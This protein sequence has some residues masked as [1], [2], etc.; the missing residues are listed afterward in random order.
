MKYADLLAL[1]RQNPDT[2]DFRALRLAYADSPEYNPYPAR[3]PAEAAITAT[4]REN[5]WMSALPAV[6]DFLEAHYLDIAAH[7]TAVRI[8]NQLNQPDQ[9]T[10][11]RTFARRLLNSIVASGDGRS[12][13]TAFVVISISEEY[14]LLRL[15]GAH[16]QMQSL[17]RH[18]GHSFDVLKA[19]VPQTSGGTA[20]V[21]LYFN[22]DIPTGWLSRRRA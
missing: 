3:H 16:L 12:P 4:L 13:E 9:E 17:V 10:Y 5:D 19:E 21:K 6:L 18:E 1:A 2:A 14:A 22:V 7:F 15:L 20:V 11:H 8:Y